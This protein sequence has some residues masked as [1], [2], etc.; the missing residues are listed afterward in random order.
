MNRYYLF[1]SDLHLR[2]ERLADGEKVLKM[3]GLIALKLRDKIKHDVV[4]VNGGDTF[5]TR[6]LIRTN[7]FDVLCSHY[8]QWA[9]KGL[10]QIII[11]GN[12]DQ[13][14]K[15]GEIHPMKAFGSFG[16][17]WVVVDEPKIV[18]RFVCF[19]YMNIEVA[20][21]FIS[22][23]MPKLKGHD[24][25]VHWGICGANRNDR[26]VDTDGVPVGVLKDFRTVVSGHYHYR[27]KFEN[28]QYIGSP[29][30]QSL[31][32]KDQ[33][34]GVILFDAVKNT[35]QFFE[36]KGTSKYQDIEVTWDEG[37][38]IVLPN[39]EASEG[40][41]CRVKV[42]GDSDLC[43]SVTREFL[44]SKYPGLTLNIERD[45]K[46]RHFSR[47]KIEASDVSDV[48]SIINRYVD[49]VDTELDRKRLLDFGK[50]LIGVV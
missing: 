12:H 28:V 37:G 7:C 29:M 19:P 5:N 48:Q 3:V 42:I 49:F 38:E 18:D 47:L 46:D 41:F 35:F 17:D 26:S 14:D 22:A 8:Q 11:V 24:A 4:I 39:V 15:V 27:H 16:K 10:R 44:R 9:S 33:L 21:K 1:Y 30:Q 23:N 40:D 43:S 36:I 45:V 13:E 6:G 31:A 32:E 50:E 34:K 2:P 25:I 20:R